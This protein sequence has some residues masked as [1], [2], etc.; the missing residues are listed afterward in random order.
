[1][2]ELLTPKTPGAALRNARENHRLSIADVV[3]ATRIKTHII[4]SMEKDDYSV[5]SASLYGK[6]F[7]KLYAEYVGLDPAPLIEYYVQYHARSTRPTLKTELP[8]P[9]VVND[10]IPVPSP[11]ARFRDASESA[12]AHTSNTL[13]T[14]LRDTGRSVVAMWG[15]LTEAR[16]A[17]PTRDP[18]AAAREFA[19]APV[20]VGRYAALGFAL[21]VVI[22]LVAGTFMLVSGR[23][24][25]KPTA[26]T[27]A[28]ERSPVV[29][30]VAVSSPLRVAEPAPRPYV[31]LK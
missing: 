18:F 2:N 9:S 24:E 22:I 3:D 13:A 26:A 5:F 16:R 21:F 6:G 23:K 28:G 8:P 20:P 14:A 4:E 19:S 7:I 15:R 27:S 25:T 11:L 1:M 12:L 17:M 10:G 30:K 31:K 29:R